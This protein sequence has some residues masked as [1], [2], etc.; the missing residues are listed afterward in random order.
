MLGTG[1]DDCTSHP[2]KHEMVGIINE[3]GAVFMQ[4]IMRCRHYIWFMKTK[5]DNEK[6]LAKAV[7]DHLKSTGWTVYPELCDI[8]I[9]ATK[10]DPSSLNGL[11][12]IGVECKKHFNL[13]V[14]AQAH[15][16]K[17][18]VDEIFVAVSKGWKNDEHFGSLVARKFGFGV[19][20]VQKSSNYYGGFNYSVD[21]HIDAEIIGRKSN[22]IEKML[23]PEAEDYAEAGQ[24]GGKH[25]SLFK[26]TALAITEH[27]TAN[28]GQSLK[29]VVA[30]VKHHY[31]NPSSARSALHKLINNNVIEGIEFRD[32][33]LYPK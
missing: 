30:S 20:F 14:L 33:L 12:I 6:E 24:A 11:K 1:Q 32:N 23:H 21:R 25:W 10:A 26:K 13:T 17:R 22:S 3:N 5:W 2:M 7:V 15:S 19:F 27:V 29:D 4:I 8:D 18:N 16:K 31:A 28:P 9:V